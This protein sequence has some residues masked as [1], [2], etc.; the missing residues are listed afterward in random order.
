MMKS[1]ANLAHEWI[2]A[3]GGE[4]IGVRDRAMP[5]DAEDEA[6]G[7][8]KPGQGREKGFEAIYALAAMKTISVHRG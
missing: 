5:F 1:H 4:H 3:V 7:V 8:K 2:I 6:G